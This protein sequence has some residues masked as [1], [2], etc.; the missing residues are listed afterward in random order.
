MNRHWAIAL[1]VVALTLTVRSFHLADAALW[2]DETYRYDLALGQREHYQASRRGLEIFYHQPGQAQ[3]KGTLRD[4]FELLR[5]D[6]PY[7]PGYFIVLHGLMALGVRAPSSLMWLNAVCAALTALLLYLIARRWLSPSSAWL[8]ALLFAM[9]PWDIAV[10]MQLR[11]TALGTMLGWLATWLL[12]RAIDTS[13]RSRVALYGLV[14]GLALVTKQQ[15]IYWLPVHFVLVMIE[16]RTATRSSVSSLLGAWLVS[17]AVVAPWLIYAGPQQWTY[18]RKYNREFS[19]EWGGIAG[20]PD[21]LVE[22]LQHSIA[23]IGQ[24]G[25]T[26]V[27]LALALLSLL[28]MVALVRR[29]WRRRRDGVWPGPKAADAVGTGVVVWGGAVSAFV[30]TYWAMRQNQALWSRYS[31]SFLPA[32][33]LMCAGAL[34]VGRLELENLISKRF[35]TVAAVSVAIFLAFGLLPH[36]ERPVPLDRYTDWNQVAAS[37]VDRIKP[38]DLV[39]HQPPFTC[40][41][42]FLHAWPTATRHIASLSLPSEAGREEI[43]KRAAGKA[44]WIILAWGQGSSAAEWKRTFA[45]A[46]WK[47]IDSMKVEMSQ[48]DGMR[49]LNSIDVVGYAPPAA[50]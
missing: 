7:A 32:V 35:S 1:A 37:L 38:G 50:L 20:L 40:M 45:E 6:S 8:A 2:E 12:Y 19:G 29:L 39:V 48:P 25:R 11:E 49:D 18:I 47:P 21:R 30:F 41:D 43:L 13:Q 34:E 36:P 22:F 23:P 4:T 33:W 16:G 17:L 9:S 26:L 24:H 31:A 44:T 10:G 5:N 46:G 14:M 15:T 28:G 27:L 42:A 3:P